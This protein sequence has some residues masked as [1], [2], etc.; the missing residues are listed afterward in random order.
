MTVVEPVKKPTV[1]GVVPRQCQRQLH[2]MV[3]GRCAL[4]GQFN[5][6]LTLKPRRFKWPEDPE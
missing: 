3:H 5:N 6:S 4:C 2:L 1:R